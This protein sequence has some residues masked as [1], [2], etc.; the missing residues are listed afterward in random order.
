MLNRSWFRQFDFLL[1]GGAVCLSLIGL[2]GIYSATIHG[3]DSDLFTKQAIWICSG[4]LLCLLVIA[5]DYRFLTDHAFFFYALTML[6]L[7][8]V[9]IFGREINGSRSWIRIGEIGIQPSEPA[10]IVVILALAS[11][12]SQLNDNRLRHKDL[13]ILAGLTLLP[14]ILITMQGDLGTALTFLPILLGT[15]LVAGLRLRFLAFVVLLIVLVAPVGWFTLK[16]HQQQRILVTLNPD[17]DPNGVGYQTRQSLIAIGSGGAM[18]KGLGNGLQSQLGFV[19]EIHSDFIFSLISEEHGF[20]GAALILSLYLAGLMRMAGIGERAADRA[21]ILIVTGVA[22]LICFHV[23][24]N[25][26]MTLGIL[27]VIGIPLP[28]LSY[29]GSSTLATFMALGLVLNVHYRRF[30]YGDAGAT[31]LPHFTYR[32]YN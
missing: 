9:L 12:L 15:M 17:L 13:A 31:S 24:I 2:V 7:V 16:D 14:V 28:L 6:V 5:I 4:V 19:P 1:F 10:K 22:S 25:V 32:S 8:G 3:A 18:G 20:L 23:F 29:G 30:I 21:G 27:P 26:G 11:Y